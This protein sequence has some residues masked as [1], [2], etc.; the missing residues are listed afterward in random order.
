MFLSMVLIAVSLC[1]AADDNPETVMREARRFYAGQ[2]YDSTISLLRTYVKKHGRGEETRYMVPLLMEALART[3]DS[4]YFR[5]LLNIY[6][7]KFPQSDFLPRL[8]YL[9][10]M[11]L[12][13]EKKFEKAVQS[14][15][16]CRN[17][18]VIGS[19]DT[20][21]LHNVTVI[22]ENELSISDMERMVG[23]QE[24][25]ADVREVLEFYI[26]YVLDKTG[27]PAK[28]RARADEF[29]KKY[30]DSYFRPLA[31][32]IASKAPVTIAEKVE[33]PI[34]K[35]GQITIGLLT[36]LSGE[37]AE[38]GK[39]ILNGVQLAVNQFNQKNELKIKLSVAD[40]R[41]NMVETAARTHDLLTQGKVPVIIG[42]VLSSDAAVS[43]GMLMDRETVM[44]TPTATDEGIAA[45]G[46]NIFQ[47]NLTLGTLARR[48]ARYAIENLNI[49]EFAIIAPQSDYGAAMAKSFK[50]E[51]VRRGGTVVAEESYEEGTRD[52]RAQFV[53]LRLKLL[54]QRYDQLAK[55]KGVTPT[56]ASMSRRADSLAVIDSV[57]SVGGLFMP[58][59]AE[60]VVMLA[61]QVAFH[62]VQTQLLGSNGWHAPS[63]ILDGKQ[64]VNNAIFSSNFEIDPASPAWTAFSAEYRKQFGSNPD[65]TIV[66]L[67]YDAANLVLSAIGSL[68][69][70][71]DPK[72][73]GEAL[74]KTS[75]YQGLSG[76]ISFEP[77]QG[78][79]T[80]T[81]IWKIKDK[82]FQRLY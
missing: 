33:K 76:P 68:G 72:R 36:P 7:R 4:Q 38:I 22:A 55:A 39:Q 32:E 65:R 43:A 14:F 35:K 9:E 11:L 12:A 59:E 2:Q 57:L 17:A 44:I 15:S 71:D 19:L 81:A 77:G 41:G 50:E 45:L 29:L 1:L 48:V 24:L 56:V 49:R 6:E 47:V 64:Y 51:I 18:G 82:K 20:L 62:R 46:R 37:N 10:G 3:N 78:V 58:A 52:F 42:P 21:S 8:Y 69:G 34:D 80:E 40:T 79:N 26:C 63:V 54:Q 13:G 74:S 16:Q 60:D 31:V 28:A 23:D 61:P 73:I 53:G 27:Q 25:N 5:K 30:S 67:G 70:S 66:P 75:G